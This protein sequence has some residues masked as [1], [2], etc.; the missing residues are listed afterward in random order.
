MWKRSQSGLHLLEKNELQR[1]FVL[2]CNNIDKS[3]AVLVRRLLLFQK[4]FS[5]R[6]HSV[7]EMLDKC[8][9]CHPVKGPRAG[10]KITFVLKLQ[11]SPSTCMSPYGHSHFE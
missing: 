3:I 1:I 11:R 2:Y 4:I 5:T 9:K 10:S 7:I 6:D 8:F